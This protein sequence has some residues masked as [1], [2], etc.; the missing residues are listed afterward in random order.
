MGMCTFEIGAHAI[1][2]MDLKYEVLLTIQT[3][4]PPKEGGDASCWETFS[5]TGL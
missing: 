3:K 4:K 5:L 1:N 2:L